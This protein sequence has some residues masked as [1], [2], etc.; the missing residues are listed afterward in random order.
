MILTV[1]EFVSY[2][3]TVPPVFTLVISI[4]ATQF[5]SDENINTSYIYTGVVTGVILR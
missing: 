3:V 4:D 5:L 2:F 1:V